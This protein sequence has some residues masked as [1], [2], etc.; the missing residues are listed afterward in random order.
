VTDNGLYVSYAPRNKV[1]TLTYDVQGRPLTIRNPLG[2][3]WT[4]TYGG[5]DLATIRN[6]LGQTVTRFSD[7][8]GRVVSLTDSLGNRMRYKWDALNRLTQITDALGQLTGFTYDANGNL[9]RMTDARGDFTDYLPD[10]MDRVQ[11][12]TDPLLRAAS[13]QYDENGNLRTFADRKGQL[14]TYTY[15]ALNRLKRVDYA[16]GSWTSQSWEVGN[17]L[18]QVTDSVSGTITWTYDELNRLT[19]DVTPQGT[20]SYG[21]D[22]AS[23]RTSM[24]VLGQPT[25]TY[26]YDF[27]DRL[28]QLT[29]A[30]ATVTVGYDDANRRT[31]LTLPNGVQA[32]YGYDTASQLTSITFKKGVTTL[33]TV[34]YTYDAAGN[35]K[36]IGGTW[37]RT[38]L[39]NPVASAAYDA[40]NQQITWGGQTNTFDLNGNLISD[41]INTYTWD[42]RNRM[43]AISGPG[44]SASFQYDPLG[45]RVS[46]TISG[47]TTSFIYDGENPVQEVQ[48][49]A[50]LANLLTGLDIDEYFT[51]TDGS[52]R[53]TL[54][55]DALGTILAL[56]DDAGAVQT[57]YTYEP[58]G[59]TTVSGQASSNPFQYTGRENDGAG[60]YYYR[61][62]YY[63]P[64]RGRFIGEDPIGLLG[65]INLFTYAMGNPVLY[66]DP[67]G[68][69]V[70]VCCR[71]V[72]GTG[73]K[74]DLHC[75]FQFDDGTTVGLYP[76]K[77]YSGG[78]WGI[79]RLGDK[80]DTG[81]YCAECQARTTCAA[82]KD[83]I[84][85]ETKKYPWG[86]YDSLG[87]N[88]NTFAATVARACCA[89]GLP[90][91]LGNAKGS[92]YDPPTKGVPVPPRIPKPLK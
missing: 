20:V 24:T 66:V 17:R 50:V 90:G 64:G 34:T 31:S 37:A 36:T 67:S 46:K 30:G 62:R 77:D 84:L 27:A 11:T 39:P 10:A 68:L 63:T 49:G 89:N 74:L 15:D 87:P 65:G 3:T 35:R 9:L 32:T 38:G 26:T 70:N 19:Q 83:C 45:R 91:D 58:F 75:Y 86:R 88:S 53:R 82:L 61:A 76:E 13:H 85:Q 16:D 59:T 33:G 28:T 69:R 8:V 71:P 23:R 21:Y 40:A 18:I 56:T 79:P 60:H 29:Q 51:R 2:H 47:T 57:S 44:I 80:R 55:A 22:A 78:T 43:V 14:R 12:R 54:L 7:A 4:F 48:G 42:A 52:G 1:S 6:P 41:G 92:G 72:L 73:S 25:L 5:P 81:G